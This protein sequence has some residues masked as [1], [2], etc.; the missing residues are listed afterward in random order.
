LFVHFS[1]QGLS[2]LPAFWH[3]TIFTRDEL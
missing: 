1:S 2:A 3:G